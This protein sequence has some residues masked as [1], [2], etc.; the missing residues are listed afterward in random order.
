MTR[1]QRDEHYLQRTLRRKWFQRWPLFYRWDVKHEKYIKSNIKNTK[2]IKT[3][4]TLS[5]T[6]YWKFEAVRKK[7]NSVAKKKDCEEAVKWERNINHHVYWVASSTTDE[8]EEM[9]L[10][11]WKSL[12][13]HIQGV[14]Q[15]HSDIFP[16]C[17]HGELK[18][19][20]RKKTWL[21]PG[22]YVMFPDI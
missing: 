9:R 7:V 17:L 12:T 3:K 19:G 22:N 2:N 14:H 5:G 1:A 18:E 15:G 16:S 21:K 8:Q 10:A 6:L 4:K 20:Q 11:R 13:N